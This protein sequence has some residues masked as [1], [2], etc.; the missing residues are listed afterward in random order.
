MECIKL[1]SFDQV[2]NHKIHSPSNPVFEVEESLHRS[3]DAEDN[4]WSLNNNDKDCMG[5]HSVGGNFEYSSAKNENV[6]FIEEVQINDW[7]HDEMRTKRVLTLLCVLMISGRRSWDLKVV[8]GSV[9]VQ[10]MALPAP[11]I[12]LAFI[13]A[14]A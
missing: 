1:W 5:N 9:R 3:V 4:I 6:V 14:Q 12:I 11:Q 13:N 8:W 10:K 7:N 2:H